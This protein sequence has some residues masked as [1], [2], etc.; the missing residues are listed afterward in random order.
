MKHL[1]F[2]LYMLS[3]ISF[4]QEETE[5]ILDPVDEAE[6]TSVNQDQV[7]DSAI[8][9]APAEDSASQPSPSK[10]I[11]RVQPNPSVQRI[12]DVVKHLGLYDRAQEVIKFSDDESS[13]SGLYLPENTGKPQGGILILHDVAQHAHWPYTTGPLRQYLPDYGWNTLSLFFEDYLSKPLPAIEK[14]TSEDP[15]QS[16]ATIDESDLPETNDLAA[17]D[18]ESIEA[19]TEEDSEQPIEDQNFED[20]PTD[21]A[22]DNI[23]SDFL[24]FDI[25]NNEAST[26]TDES[27]SES[28]ETLFV[29]AMTERVEG[30][31]RQLNTLGQFNL[32]VV[33]HGLSANWAANTL[34]NRFEQNPGVKG[35]ALVLIDAKQ[36]RYPPF[37]LNETLAQFD[38]PILDINTSQNDFD[39]RIVKTRKDTI[40]REQKAQYWQINLPSI[41]NSSLGQQTM[42]T[43][44]VRGWLKTHAAGEKV[45]VA[46]KRY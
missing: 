6:S 1:L 42:I 35:Y 46:E 45:N 2:L 19:P 17:V 29:N 14:Q 16:D 22:L 38:I 43:R 4:A 37:P 34:K 7:E 27:E 26:E 28:N 30:G 32:V 41:S 40:V 12:K 24:P 44:R 31:L 39:T 21:D 36:S 8:E 11:S 20:A 18:D 33:A 13:I 5:N 10:P 9:E 23:A 15:A 25:P 3:A